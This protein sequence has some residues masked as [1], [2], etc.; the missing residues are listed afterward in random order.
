MAT[1]AAAQALSTL[2]RSETLKWRHMPRYRSKKTNRASFSGRIQTTFW[3]K[4]WSWSPGIRPSK[5]RTKA[6]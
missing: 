6:R 2:I 1:E 4:I 3:R 5:R